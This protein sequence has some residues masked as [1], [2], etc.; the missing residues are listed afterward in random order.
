MNNYN[1]DRKSSNQFLDGKVLDIINKEDD[2]IE[3]TII[4]VRDKKDK[5]ESYAAYWK[6]NDIFY[7]ISGKMKKQEFLKLIDNMYF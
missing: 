1:D 3:I 7:Q 4:K 2:E 6:M 5:K